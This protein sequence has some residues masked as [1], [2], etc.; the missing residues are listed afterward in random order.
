MLQHKLTQMLQIE[1]LYNSDRQY[2]M[3]SLVTNNNKTEKNIQ[4]ITT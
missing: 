1:D 3:A 2:L 4:E